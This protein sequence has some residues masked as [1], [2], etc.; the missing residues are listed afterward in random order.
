[1]FKN[2]Y[3]NLLTIILIVAIVA[4]LGIGAF[5]VAR[6]FKNQKIRRENEQ[7]ISQ[8]TDN[9]GEIIDSSETEEPVGNVDE[10]TEQVIE[11][12]TSIQSAGITKSSSSGTRKKTYYPDTNFVVIGYI[13]IPK[14]K[15]LSLSKHY[16]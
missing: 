14:T 15:M 7:V 12:I 5:L 8:F 13:E 9:N 3:S 1:M 11:E 6:W 2:K 4:I 10:N 16:G